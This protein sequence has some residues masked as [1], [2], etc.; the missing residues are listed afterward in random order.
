MRN[1][2]ITQNV[3]LDGRIEMLDDWFDPTAQDAELTRE[4]QRQ[5]EHCDA[6]LL[7]RQTFEDF[8]GYWPQQVGTDTT[9]A[10]D[11]LQQVAK[12]VVSGTLTVPQWRHSTVL[13]GDVAEEVSALKQQPGKDVVVTG[14]ITLTHALL[15][16]GLVD[17][18]RL[19]GY[20]VVQGRG[21]GLFPDGLANVRLR[22]LRTDVFATSGVTFAEYALP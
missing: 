20:P 10:A 14:S 8:R 15:G 11:F 19:F 18:I 13:S 3:T 5:D 21:R 12:Y 7:G 2:V 17:R 1:L 9:G 4:L 22:L 6:V 16:A